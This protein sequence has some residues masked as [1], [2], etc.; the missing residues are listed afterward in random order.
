MGGSLYRHRYLAMFM[1]LLVAAYLAALGTAV[2]RIKLD[3]P[4]EG[5]LAV[6]WAGKGAGFS[7]SH[8][9]NQKV[10][11]YRN[12]YFFL[13]WDWRPVSRLRIDPPALSRGSVRG[14]TV[15][16]LG[17]ETV[18]LSSG[19]RLTSLHAL[20]DLSDINVGVDRVSY[21]ATGDD[22]QFELAL[23]PWSVGDIVLDTAVVL[24]IVGGAIAG[25]RLLVRSRSGGE[26]SAWT[27]AAVYAGACFVLILILAGMHA[28]FLEVLR[29]DAFY[30]MLTGMRMTFGD[31]VPLHQHS[32]GWPMVLALAFKIAD[33][34]SVF[35][36]MVL[37]RALSVLVTAL[38]VVPFYGLCR[39]LLDERGTVIALTA[40]ATSHW[41]PFIGAEAMSEPL[42]VFLSLCALYVLVDA[43]RS[44]L[45][46]LAGAAAGGLAYY[47]RPDGLFMLGVALFVALLAT[48]RQGRNAYLLLAVPLVFFA[49]SFFHLYPRYLAFGSP[50]D[51]GENSKY[52][53]ESYRQVWAPNVPAPTLHEYLSTHSW[54]EIYRKFVT[55]GL[56]RAVRYIPH[57]A[58]RGWI[59]LMYA[60]VLFYGLIRR[61]TKVLVLASLG[62]AYVVALSAVAQVFDS[63]RHVFVLVP[64]V[65]LLAA[66]MA[67]CMLG[68]LRNDRLANLATVL[69][70]GWILMGVRLPHNPLD[71]A[72]HIPYVSDEWAQWS[73]RNLYGRI[74]IVDGGD[75]IDMNQPYQTLGGFRS[76]DRAEQEQVIQP[77]RPGLYNS[78]GEALVDF[79][80]QG[81]TYVLVDT[82]NSRARPYLNEADSPQY[83]NDLELVR[84]FKAMPDESWVVRDM[85]VY[86]VRYH[87]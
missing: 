54:Q 43:D 19:D 86:R 3:V 9:V 40:L 49:V 6:Y 41:L 73:A 20:N 84:R 59:Y 68:W 13:I 16:R 15:W 67:G 33:V 4:G 70:V 11:R 62:A 87:G 53:V 22:P 34:Q 26:S 32:V 63:I 48:R 10:A 44:V 79:R 69:V 47:A 36:G 21:R 45:R 46:V 65:L 58:E 17:H 31:W 82:L 2:V 72:F 24:L 55:E 66:K 38:W 12:D 37:T 78:L 42:F 64:V 30:Y 5:V 14:V 23:A 74:A 75:L 52:F 8:E 18:A 83:A 50:F 80:K 81:V 1:V 25:A 28:P 35:T 60:S 57:L 51:Y 29:K 85:R 76:L 27:F 61:D 56:F 77:F 39:K 7:E 71:E